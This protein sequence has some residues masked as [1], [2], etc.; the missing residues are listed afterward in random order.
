MTFLEGLGIMRRDYYEVL[1]VAKDADARAIKK[2]YRALAMQ[3]HPDRNDTPEAEEKFKEA[4]EAYEVLSDDNKRAIYDRAGFDGLRG[5]GF[6]GF[7]GADAQDIFSSFGDIFGDMF[8]FGGGNARGRSRARRGADLRYDMTVSFKE[9]A[10]GVKKDIQV[11]QMQGCDACHGSGGESGSEPERCHACGGRGQIVQGQGLFLMQTPCVAC[12]GRG[13]RHAKPCKTCRG[14]GQ[15]P[16]EKKLTITLPAGFASGMSL[17]Y[18]GQGESGQEGGPPG[19][20]YIAVDVEP[21]ATLTREENDLRVEVPVTMIEAALGT[22]VKVEGIDGAEEV[23]VAAGT[24]P[25]DV[26]RLRKKGVPHLRG[27]G[28]G[29]LLVRVRVEV[30][31]S[32]SQKERVLLEQLAELQGSA[33]KKKR[34]LF[35]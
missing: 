24:Q 25:G 30:P 20:L 3:Y 27:Q 5:Q 7:S 9:A 16:T 12:G 33:I 28:R 6:S 10:F 22:R 23:T 1:Q 21:H 13:A 4:S 35:S 34:G 2:A 31:R 15:T 17:R 32:V 14:E 8:G 11:A 18:T 29:D 26:V 19:D